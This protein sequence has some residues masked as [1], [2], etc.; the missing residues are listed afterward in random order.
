[1]Q[2]RDGKTGGGLGGARYTSHLPQLNPEERALLVGGVEQTP[3]RLLLQ[4]GDE[5]VKALVDELMSKS[6]RL[7]AAAVAPENVRAAAAALRLPK[8]PPPSNDKERAEL[9]K[10]TPA[11][12]AMHAG[13]VEVASCWDHIR[14]PRAREAASGGLRPPSAL[15]RSD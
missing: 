3:W 1:M 14:P 6:A 12:R 9:E 7:K 2:R 15:G 13:A 10:K 4:S 5:P 11:E 8:L